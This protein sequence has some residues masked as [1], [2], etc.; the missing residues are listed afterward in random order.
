MIDW[1]KSAELNNTT[2]EKLQ[3]RFKKFPKSNK[4]IIRI[5][6]E[7]GKIDKIK[8]VEYNKVKYFN[9]CRS[10]SVKGDRSPKWTG[11]NITLICQIC[12]KEY[13]VNKDRSLTSKFCS[14]ECFQK[15]QVINKKCGKDNPNYKGKIILICE[16]C[17]KDFEVYPSGKNKR[18][19][20][21]ECYGEWLSINNRGENNPAYGK[22]FSEEHCKKL[23]ESHKG[24]CGKDSPSWNPNITDEERLIKRQYPKYHEW[25]QTVYK[26]DNY[27]CQCCNN[28]GRLNAHHI[29]SYANNKDLR[30]EL[31]NGI[32]LCEACHNDFHHLY[33]NNCN[34]IQLIKFLGSY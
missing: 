27:I 16:Q 30:I 33:G 22:K 3:K 25:R 4:L 2:I 5:C 13:K 11:G 23:S 15:W 6:D 26:R 1:E 7:C 24:K 18:F 12:D 19:C 17:G 34:R 32:T 28:G 31:D 21:H 20:T 8:F 9:L 10:C 29:E 14:K